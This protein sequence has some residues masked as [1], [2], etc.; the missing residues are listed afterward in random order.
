MLNEKFE[1]INIKDINV[2]IMGGSGPEKKPLNEILL[3]KQI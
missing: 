3:A 1:S 2:Y